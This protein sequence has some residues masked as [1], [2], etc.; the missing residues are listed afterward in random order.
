MRRNYFRC[1]FF[2][3]HKQC[4]TPLHTTPHPVLFL[5]CC[6]S[7]CL[8]LSIAYSLSKKVTLFPSKRFYC[9]PRVTGFPSGTV[10]RL[11]VFFIVHIIVIKHFFCFVIYY[12]YAQTFHCAHMNI[13]GQFVLFAL[14][15]LYGFCALDS[16]R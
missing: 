6:F 11:K 7:L 9:P 14:P 2:P 3:L 4:S 16:D 1:K 5:K 10:N 8:T 13:R 12:L 15:S